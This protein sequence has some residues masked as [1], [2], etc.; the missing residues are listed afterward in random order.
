MTSVA[1]G[2]CSDC[3]RPRKPHE[4]FC[5]C[6]A[7]LDYTSPGE[8]RTNGKSLPVADESQATTSEW[9]PGPY[10]EES[11]ESRAPTTPGPRVIHCPNT[12]C[13]AVNPARHLFCWQ[14]KLPLHEGKDAP[15]PWNWRRALRLEKPPLRAR[16]RQR[17]HLPF[18]SKSPLAIARSSAIVLGVLVAVAALAIGAVKGAQYGARHG[19]TWFSAARERVFP[20]FR[21]HHPS[22]VFPTR[23]RSAKPGKKRKGVRTIE[24]RKI[25][26][27][28]TVTVKRR[29]T[30][31]SHPAVDAFDRNLSTYWQSTT[32]RQTPDTVRLTFK[33]PVDEFD[34]VSVFGGDP[35]GKTIVPRQLQVA[36]YTWLP[37]HPTRDCNLQP[38][39]PEHLRKKGTF[40]VTGKPHVLTLLNTPAEQ[41][42]SFGPQRHIVRIVITIRGTHHSDNP[43]AKAA[44]TDIEFFD[45]F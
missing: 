5:E 39:Q 32:K 16:E 40:C 10:E 38:G 24:V 37:N 1:A 15:E 9:P 7:L 28:R 35:T 6:G 41:R 20:R 31:I 4:I 25:V 27:G 30:T 12:K 43:K 22:S 34:D 17:K 18:F 26:N 3:G 33:P 23:Y 29:V 21:P 13:E 42:F 11:Y 19:P 2:T 14:C 44:I 8:T 36:F 45:R